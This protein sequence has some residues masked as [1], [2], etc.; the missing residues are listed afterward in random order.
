MTPSSLSN[1]Y[2]LFEEQVSTFKNAAAS[3]GDV[4]RTMLSTMESGM[5]PSAEHVSTF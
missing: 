3:A 1:D 2:S 5:V 4:L